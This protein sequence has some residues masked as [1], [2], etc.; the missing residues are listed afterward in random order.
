MTHFDFSVRRN[1]EC[2]YCGK[3]GNLAK[4]NYKIKNH[5]SKQRYIRHNGNF[6]HKDTS[7]SDGFKNINLFIFEAALFVETDDE[8]AWFIDSGASTHMSCN[9]EWYDEYYEN[10]DG[11]HIYL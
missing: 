6:V 2:D 10:I 3:L 1:V 8:N 5:E 7:V 9:K 11:T 4:D